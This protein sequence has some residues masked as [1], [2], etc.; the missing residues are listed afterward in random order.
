MATK[1]RDMIHGKIEEKYIYS[2]VRV[3]GPTQHSIL[4]LERWIR[5][6]LREQER[7][8]RWQI[9]E[10]K[11]QYYLWRSPFKNS[12]KELPPSISKHP[13]YPVSDI[14]IPREAKPAG[15]QRIKLPFVW[16]LQSQLKVGIPPRP[17]ISKLLNSLPS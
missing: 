12:A 7:G 11:L 1:E 6:R 8:M 10:R 13:F 14:I 16:V 3:A 9:W 17:P 15:I 5:T 4:M 2:I